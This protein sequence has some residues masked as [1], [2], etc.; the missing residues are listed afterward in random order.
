MK[1]LLDDAVLHV[2]VGV[3]RLVIVD[4]LPSFDEDALALE[5]KG[6]WVKERIFSLS[7]KLSQKINRKIKE[8]K[9]KQVVTD[10]RDVTSGPVRLSISQNLTS[11][12]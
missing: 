2:D 3:E 4:D 6:F 5:H 8:K 7:V 9:T 11:L 1:R 12:K 10:T